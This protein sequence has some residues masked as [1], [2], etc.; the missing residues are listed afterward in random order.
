M[1]ATKPKEMFVK[2][3][4]V[5]N[6]REELIVDF[7]S[8]ES[9]L[10]HVIMLV[11]CVLFFFISVILN[12]VSAVTILTTPILKDK[13]SYLTVMVKS[14]I[15]FILGLTILPQYIVLLAMEIAGNPNCVAYL[16]AKKLGVLLY[17]YSV[18]ALSA[19][20]FE[21]YMAT[22]HPVTH[23]NK[24]KKEKLLMYLLFVSLFAT[25]LFGLSFIYVNILPF[26]LAATVLLLIASTIYVYTMISI[27]RV[28]YW[29]KSRNAIGPQNIA[30]T[31]DRTRQFWRSMKS[32]NEFK[33]A[34]WCLLIVVFTLSCILPST[35]SYTNRLGTQPSY[36]AV[37]KRRHYSLLILFNSALNPVIFFW[38]NKTLRTAAIKMLR[39][40]I[41]N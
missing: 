38:K 22:I 34:S 10:E 33:V 8:M 14:I 17:I 16:F 2:S 31:N 29:I 9:Q 20:N 4:Q 37:S 23:R 6:D 18:T 40:Q 7:P 19:M 13:I 15:D 32:S 36:S 27:S 30:E 21:R 11:L 24:F 26:V 41:E 1:N 28:R 3:C 12:G 39:R 35:V 5:L 25:V